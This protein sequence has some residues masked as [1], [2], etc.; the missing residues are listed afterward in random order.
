[1]VAG[2]SNGQK[3]WDLTERCLPAW[4]PRERLSAREISRRA[5]ERSLRALGVA[6]ARQI[7]LHFIRS[8][9]D[10]LRQVLQQLETEGRIEQVRIAGGGRDWPGPWYVH[11]DTLPLLERLEDGGWA[12]RTTLLSPFDNLICDRARTSLMFG[13]DFRLEIYV[14]PAQRRYGFFV[15]PVLHHDRLI[16]RI[17]QAMD[18]ARG[19]LRVKAV[20]AEPG[21]PVT[22]GAGRAVAGA[23]EDLAGFL[24]ARQIEYPNAVPAGWRPALR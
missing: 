20:H 10:N 18:R 17:D 23:I 4:T 16:G 15:M 22:R 24:G 13:F 9:Y 21:A 6:T 19:V 14:P 3:L 11:T 8:R 12:P 2:R 1:M 7:Q 5:A